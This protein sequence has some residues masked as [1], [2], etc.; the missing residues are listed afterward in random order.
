MSENTK[1]IG[2]VGTYTKGNSE[3]IY[4]FTLDTEAERIQDVRAVA[5]LDNPTYVE[6]SHDNQFL[7]SVVK[8]GEL[9]GAAAYS[10]HK[11]TGELKE[12]NK[13]LLEGASPCH[14]S[15]DDKHHTVVTANYHKGTVEAY[16]INVDGSLKPAASIIEH[17]GSGPNKERQEKPH[18]HYAGFTP[19]EKYVAVVDLGID[20]L[21]TYEVN[22]GQLKELNHLS[23]KPGSGPRH[24]TFHPNG[25]FA[26]LMTEMSS[27]V[28]ALKYNHEDGSF[29]ELQYIS[30]IP[31]NFTENSQGSAIHISSDGR[32]VYAANRGHNSIAIF[33]VN[34]DSGELKFVEHTPT[35]GDWPRDFVLDPTEKFLIASNQN[36]SNLVLYR[37]NAT[38]GKLTLIQSDVVV[39]DPVCVKFL[40][41]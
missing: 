27:E 35:E 29:T 36:S 13:Q 16:L 3:G 5:K 30:A 39:P 7:Y 15:V 18:V 11:Q 1:F 8:E 37:R 23:V 4:T 34:Q 28:A 19:D 33:S 12:I 9:G 38:T 22:Y 41:R 26:Y 24:L 2:Y 14:V 25:R 40:N 17:K 21:I 6:I 20:Q 31:D 10:I 32:F